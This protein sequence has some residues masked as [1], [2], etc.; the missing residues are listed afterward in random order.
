[1]K[2]LVL[3]FSTLLVL[4]SGQAHAGAEG[5]G[6]SLVFI[7]GHLEPADLHYSGTAPKIPSNYV[8]I[9]FKDYPKAL[10]ELE[11]AINFLKARADGDWNSRGMF[12]EWNVEDTEFYF[13][14]T[15]RQIA[16]RATT[17]EIRPFRR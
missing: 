5:H 6:G 16:L 11:Y 8:P 9:N 12:G 4:G 17:S 13:V 1:M 3:I 2:N 14:P 10:R 7:D 15:P